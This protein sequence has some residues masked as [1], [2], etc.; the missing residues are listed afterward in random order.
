MALEKIRSGMES[1]EPVLV[2]QKA[3]YFVRKNELLELN[4]P[5]SKLLG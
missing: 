4:F 3:V 2:G 1:P 5:L